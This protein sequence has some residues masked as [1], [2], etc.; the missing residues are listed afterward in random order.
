MLVPVTPRGKGGSQTCSLGLG[1]LLTGPMLVFE[2]A[3]EVRLEGGSWHCAG[4]VEVKQQGQWGTVCGG[5]FWEMSDA[6]VVCKQLGCGSAL[7][8]HEEAHFGPGSGPIWMFGVECDG[9]ESAL[10]DCT[11]TEWVREYCDHRLDA[12]VTC[13]GKGPAYSLPLWP[14]WG[15]G[16]GCTLREQR[17]GTGAGPGVARHTAE[18]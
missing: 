9:T 13:S 6:A 11:N 7:E 15:K 14:G 2:G 3:A 1:A 16:P 12:G 18:L 8:A 10:S 17:R 4:R 5:Y